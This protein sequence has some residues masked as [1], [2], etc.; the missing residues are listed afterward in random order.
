MINQ[1]ELDLHF[2]KIALHEVAC[3]SEDQNEKVGCVIVSSNSLSHNIIKGYNS[4]PKNISNEGMRLKNRD[5]KN[6]LT[7][8]AELN[9]M[10]KANIDISGW[11][12]YV[13]KPP[14]FECA[15]AIIQKGIQ[16]VVCPALRTSS[17]WHFNQVR[18]QNLLIEAGVLNTF[19]LPERFQ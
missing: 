6:E 11:T 12:L 1:S 8:H 14:C 16:R 4:F 17:N 9:A 13:T 18:A 7:V 2:M 19:Y 10:L 5:L 15:K 3:W